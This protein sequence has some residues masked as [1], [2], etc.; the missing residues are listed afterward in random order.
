MVESIERLE[1][2][3]SQYVNTPATALLIFITSHVNVHV[4]VI[5]VMSV[6]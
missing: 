6:K 2:K 1:D 4:N 3:W 5:Y